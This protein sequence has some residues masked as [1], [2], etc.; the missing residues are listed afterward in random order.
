MIDIAELHDRRLFALLDPEA[1]V[2]PEATLL[3]WKILD[4]QD[5]PNAGADA[6]TARFDA[7]ITE[8][9]ALIARLQSGD[10]RK[11]ADMLSGR[12]PVIDMASWLANHNLAHM[13]QLQARL[14]D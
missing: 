7:A 12:V 13:A 5:Y 4:G 11:K 2:A 3:P 6:L 1:N 10:W 8:A 14:A 9:L